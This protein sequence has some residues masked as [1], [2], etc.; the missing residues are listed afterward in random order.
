MTYPDGS[1]VGVGDLVWWNEG[2]SVG[3]VQVVAESKDDYESWGLKVPSIF[4]SNRH[5]FDRSLGTGVAYDR[6][7]FE[8]EGI[9]LLSLEELNQLE[10]ATAEA[11]R[12]AT[13]SF[14]TST[15]SVTT[16]VDKCQQVGWV[17]T[18]FRD[19]REVEVLKVAAIPA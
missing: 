13:A 18:L 5:P 2:H 15:Y 12:L 9:G 1:T 14:D 4:L 17:F 16:E 6:A 19:G 8:D 11:R 7:S 3:Y 10:R